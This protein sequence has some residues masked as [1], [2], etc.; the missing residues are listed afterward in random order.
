ML[1]LPA[2]ILVIFGGMGDLIWRMLVPAVYNLQLD[3]QL[4]EQFAIIGLDQV[5]VAVGGFRCRL[6]DGIHRFSRRKKLMK[7]SG[8]RSPQMAGVGSNPI[9]NSRIESC[10]NLLLRTASNWD[11]WQCFDLAL[12]DFQKNCVALVM[13]DHPNRNGHIFLTPQMTLP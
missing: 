6:R 11:G 10:F 8:S 13:I 1:T 2:T 9:F 3:G 12:V 4:P 5:Q 7:R